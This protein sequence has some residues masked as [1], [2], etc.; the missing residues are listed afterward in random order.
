MDALN[1]VTFVHEATHIVQK[2]TYYFDVTGRGVADQLSHQWASGAYDQTNIVDGENM[3]T[4]L[5][6]SGAEGHAVLVERFYEVVTEEG[7]RTRTEVA[8]F[9]NSE[10][11][12]NWRDEAKLFER[13][14]WFPSWRRR[15]TR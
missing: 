11:G 5:Q 13:A 1:D 7:A 12:E 9:L 14:G 15:P 6:R 10:D 4:I 2:Q 8:E 3:W